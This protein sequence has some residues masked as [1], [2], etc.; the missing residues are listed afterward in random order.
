M[1]TLMIIGAGDVA[2]RALPELTRRWRVLALCRSNASAEAL[3]RQGVTPILGDLDAPRALRRLAGLADDLLLT[4]PPRKSA[5]RTCACASCCL[6]WQK[7]AG[8][9]SV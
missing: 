6:R 1:R 9:H 3:R 8:Y 5:A 2:R 7:V 4:A